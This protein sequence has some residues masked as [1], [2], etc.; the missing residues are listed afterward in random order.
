METWTVAAD[1]GAP[2]G[3]LLAPGG[4][5]FRASGPLPEPAE[6]PSPRPVPSAVAN[7]S[8]GCHF[9]AA[10]GSPPIDSW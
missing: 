5:W 8:G 9:P 10:P 4:G 2:K 1:E 7:R 3:E 6:G